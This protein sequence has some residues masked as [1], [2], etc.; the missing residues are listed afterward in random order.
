MTLPLAQA[1]LI[2]RAIK[3]NLSGITTANGYTTEVVLV[4]EQ[5]DPIRPEDA[6]GTTI[7]ISDFEEDFTYRPGGFAISQFR[8]SVVGWLRDADNGRLRSNLRVFASELWVRH[9]QDEHLL[10]ANVAL[11]GSG[12]LVNEHR[13][14]K[15]RREYQVPDGLILVQCSGRYDFNVFATS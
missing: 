12:V 11:G 13:I 2:L 10:T 8:Y 4:D 3:Q 6:T 15:I 14:E 9:H 1:N 7:V 5:D